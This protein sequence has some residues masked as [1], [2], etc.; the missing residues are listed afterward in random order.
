VIAGRAS[1]AF[2]RPAPNSSSCP[3]DGAGD[4][5]CASSFVRRVRQAIKHVARRRAASFRD[6]GAVTS[7]DAPSGVGRTAPSAST[8][9]TPSATAASR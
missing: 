1:S 5:S 3:A 9:T 2:V 8:V 6:P 7:S 4:D